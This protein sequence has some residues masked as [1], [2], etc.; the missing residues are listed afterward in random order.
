MGEYEYLRTAHRVYGKGIRKMTR[1]TGHS[2]NTI[3]RA[4]I[5]E[6]T[7]YSKRESQP[8]Q[9]L[10]PYLDIIDGWLKGDRERSKK[11]RHTAR[12]IYTRLCSEYGYEGSERTLQEYLRKAKLELGTGNK[13]GSAIHLRQTGE[14]EP[15]SRGG[16]LRT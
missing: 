4:L 1:E 14:P 16:F 12:R 13:D 11:Q 6:Y 2:R 8:H 7:G 10:G 15:F 9:V 5:L 3:R